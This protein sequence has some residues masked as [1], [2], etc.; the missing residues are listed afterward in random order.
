MTIPPPTVI[1]VH[2][3]DVPAPRSGQSVVVAEIETMNSN[4]IPNHQTS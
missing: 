2:R 4:Q 1:P 3:T